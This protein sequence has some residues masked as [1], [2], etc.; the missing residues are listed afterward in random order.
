M[1]ELTVSDRD[2]FETAYLAPIRELARLVHLLPASA[3]GPYAAPAGLFHLCV[4]VAF[5]T[6]QSADGKIFT[7]NGT[8]EDRHRN[9]PRWRYACFLAGLCCLVQRTLTQLTVTTAGGHEWPRFSTSLWAWLSA[10]TDQRYFVNWHTRSSIGAGEGAAFLNFVAPKERMD[11]LSQGDVQIVRDMH[12]VAM[13]AAHDTDSIM[14]GV[15]NRIVKRVLEIDDARRRSRYGRLT[16]GT[17]V[18]PYVL[19][20]LRVPIESRRWK[21]NQPDSPV[22]LASDGL[23][24]EWPGAHGDVLRHF[25]ELGLPGLPRSAMTLAEILGKAELLIQAES[26]LWVREVL[27]PAASP[28][29]RRRSTAMRFV[30]FT[31]IL[32]HL[33]FESMPGP[34]GAELVEAELKAGAASVGPA[35]AK[36]KGDP[37]AQRRDPEPTVAQSAA[38]ASVLGESQDAEQPSPLPVQDS[39]EIVFADLIKPEAK[40]WI[41]SPDL[42]EAL[43]HLIDLHKRKR[44]EAAKTFPFGVALST[45]WIS[46]NTVA[47]IANLV[48]VLERNRWLGR[49]TSVKNEALKLHELQFDDGVK[50]AIVL[51]HTGATA[52][53]FD[54]GAKRK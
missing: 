48:G 23:F 21:V 32:G 43:G 35:S 22:W 53:G 47:D 27:V 44:G 40:R 4:D 26:G 37:D 24:I 7:P 12:Q 30:D 20:A 13:G 19:D 38:P 34:V 33:E 11:W 17:H 5:Y 9:E 29:E 8:V 42:C 2:N 54:V 45:D 50:R 51:S 25:D 16:I 31:A 1:R 10:G 3:D 18:E 41:T 36:A 28:G 15:V 6:L 14:A 49:P 46:E 39:G 52:L